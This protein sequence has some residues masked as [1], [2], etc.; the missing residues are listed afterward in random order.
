[1]FYCWCDQDDTLSHAKLRVKCREC[2]NG[3]IILHT[4][5]CSWDDVLKSDRIQ[6]YCELCQAVTWAEFYF[7]CGNHKVGSDGHETV[8]LELIRSNI[9]HVPCL[10][11]TDTCDTVIVF[12]CDHVT[13]SQCWVDYTKSR[14]N[15]RQFI[16]DPEVGYTLPCPLSCDN[17]LVSQ[18]GH[19]K[20]M[21]SHH[22]QRYLRYYIFEN[23]L[24]ISWYF[25]VYV[26]H[27]LVNTLTITKYTLIIRFVT[28]NVGLEPRS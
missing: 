27:D 20:L 1:M 6:G 18:P 12:S 7:R 3:A 13:C 24:T 17:S 23:R 11:C 16:L 5:P 14:L 19:F 28:Y 4:D 15:D 26:V 22:Y 9:R 8:A 10:A 25:H 2:H 21:T